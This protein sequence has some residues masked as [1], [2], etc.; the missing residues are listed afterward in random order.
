MR[1]SFSHSH[2]FPGCRVTAEDDGA[3]EEAGMIEFGDG[4]TVIGAWRRD[5]DG[6]L[7]DIPSYR[8]AR[9]TDVAA[10]GWRLTRGEDGDWR[11]RRLD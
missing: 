1:F 7:L 3:A 2:A 10:H 4:V 11:A 9:G 5:G 6:V 8:T